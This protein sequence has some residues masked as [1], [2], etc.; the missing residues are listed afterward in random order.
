MEFPNGFPLCGS[1]SSSRDRGD[2]AVEATPAL[3]DQVQLENVRVPLK[4]AVNNQWRVDAFL[5]FP[6]EETGFGLCASPLHL[7]Q[8]LIGLS[9][10]GS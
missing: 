9:V 5:K 3:T 4:I 1:V 6:G 8:S 2:R 10:G 7:V